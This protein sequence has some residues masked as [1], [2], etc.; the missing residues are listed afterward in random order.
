MKKNT[1]HPSLSALG[2]GVSEIRLGLD[3]LTIELA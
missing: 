3:V 1:P 2:C